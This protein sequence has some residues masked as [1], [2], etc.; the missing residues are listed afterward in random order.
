MMLFLKEAKLS[1][2][3]YSQM[4]KGPAQVFSN[5]SKKIPRWARGI[6]A[7]WSVNN[8]AEALE[9][10]HHFPDGLAARFEKRLLV[11]AK[12]KLYDLFN[13]SFAKN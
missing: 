5:A 10:I 4:F 1:P 6:E 9:H 3:V 12:I 11:L 2:Q 7:L 13:S 8:L